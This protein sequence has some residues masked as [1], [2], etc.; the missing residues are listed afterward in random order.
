MRFLKTSQIQC[1]A[2]NKKNKQPCKNKAL[3]EQKY[4]AAHLGKEVK[5]TTEDVK[6]SINTTQDPN[7][8]D[9]IKQL[10][11]KIQNLEIDPKYQARADSKLQR[12]I[13]AEEYKMPIIPC[14]GSN[15]FTL[16]KDLT[17]ESCKMRSFESCLLKIYMDPSVD[18]DF[19][20]TL[21]HSNVKYPFNCTCGHSFE[22]SLDE[23]SCG[24][25]CSYCREDHYLLCGNEYCDDCRAKSFMGHEK[26]KYLSKKNTI[27]PLLISIKSEKKL[28]FDCPVCEHEFESMPQEICKGS[29]CPYCSSP[30]RK[31]CSNLSCNHCLLHSFA[32]H[33]RSKGFKELNGVD[34]RFLFMHNDTKKYKFQ[35]EKCPHQYETTI[36]SVTT[37]NTK[38]PYCLR[39]KFCLTGCDFCFLNSYASCKQSQFIVNK[40]IDPRT[41]SKNSTRKLDLICFHCWKQYKSAPQ[42]TINDSACKCKS[43]KTENKFNDFL[44][45]KF[46]EKIEREMRFGWCRNVYCLPFDFC[47]EEYKI[48]IEIDGGH[49][50]REIACWY[51]N[52]KEIQERDLYKMK[53]ANEN[54]YSVIRI[55]QI[56]VWKNREN[57]IEQ[58][59]NVLKKYETPVNICIGKIYNLHPIYSSLNTLNLEVE[60]QKD[61]NIIF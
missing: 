17:C 37:D 26:A 31:L 36:T 58:L 45:S 18:L 60:E 8:S 19:R 15:K 3:L 54:G 41:F 16:C 11:E 49:H 29:W 33:P 44:V 12:E 27:N 20:M 23:V 22:K 30:P 50:F 32:S 40:K 52:T 13:Y 59:A 51:T 2:I 10:E 9:D 42:S 46:G 34:P 43:F 21:K 28:W 1:I 53:C 56:I 4:C 5:E 6:T 14:P 61:E 55:D 57:W 25:F 38:C 47:I 39:K 24:N 48:L 35:C 7:I